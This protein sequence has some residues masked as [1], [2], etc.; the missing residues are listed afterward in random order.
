MA[1]LLAGALFHRVDLRRISRGPSWLVALC[2]GTALIF[3]SPAFGSPSVSTLRAG[4]M[5]VD[6]SPGKLWSIDRVYFRGRSIMESPSS[7]GTIV[8]FSDGVWSGEGH[9]RETL[10]F[11]SLLVDGVPSLLE[12]DREYRG[13]I[14]TLS[15]V[16]L[17]DGSVRVRDALTI[18]PDGIDRSVWLEGLSPERNISFAYVV[19]DTRSNRLVDLALQNDDE[20]LDQASTTRDDGSFYRPQSGPEANTIRQI[21]PDSDD[22]VITTWSSDSAGSIAPWVWDRA[23]DNKLYLLATTYQNAGMNLAIQIS[24]RFCH[25]SSC[26]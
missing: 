5:L 15:R 11:V 14:L 20:T 10:E 6:I 12:S 16:V 8:G 22:G 3:C 4:F 13:T 24:I 7:N 19:G 9:G 17:L 1:V 25:G 23:A 18:S 21:D 26:Q 2:L